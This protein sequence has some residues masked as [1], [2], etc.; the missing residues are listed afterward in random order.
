MPWS[1]VP[2]GTHG[3]GDGGDGGG[4]AAL[5]PGESRGFPDLGPFGAGLL[6][7]GGRGA[8][9]GFGLSAM[10][11]AGDNGQLGLPNPY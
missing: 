1:G 9:S 6:C 2:S 8:G 4:G 3:R 5:V 7:P 11:S 10:G